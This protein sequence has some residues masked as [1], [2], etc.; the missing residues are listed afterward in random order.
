M[1]DEKFS[2]TAKRHHRA[3]LAQLRRTFLVEDEVEIAIQVNGKVR[4][5][6]VVPLDATDEELRATALANARVQRIH[7][8][9]DGAQGR[10]HPQKAC[11]HRRDLHK[12]RMWKEFKEFAIK[13]NAIDLA[14]GVIIGAAFG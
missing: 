6:I 2:D 8:G 1:L 5:K 11:Q 14:V 13:G 9:Q 7:R 3:A 10:G 4:D 12:T